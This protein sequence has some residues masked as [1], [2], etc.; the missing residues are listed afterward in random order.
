MKL[1]E[2]IVNPVRAGALD[3]QRYLIEEFDDIGYDLTMKMGFPAV[4]FSISLP[5]YKETVLLSYC[6][7]IS[8]NGPGYI[9]QEAI[10]PFNVIG[11]QQDTIEKLM[12][13]LI[14]TLAIEGPPH[15]DI[16]ESF[17]R[18][19]QK[20]YSFADAYDSTGSN[21]NG[22]SDATAAKILTAV[23]KGKRV[24]V[25]NTKKDMAAEPLDWVKEGARYTVV[26]VVDDKA[27]MI[28]K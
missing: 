21:T 25:V 19:F 16:T 12:V 2:V 7:G 13:E 24:K 5:Y 15:G 11:K 20:A 27:L 6:V 23:L 17:A 26:T 1:A 4:E 9:A 10:D 8:N 28:E 3:I 14:K 22:F 18:L